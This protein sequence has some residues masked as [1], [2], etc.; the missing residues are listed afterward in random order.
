[1][2]FEYV[3]HVLLFRHYAFLCCPHDHVVRLR[4]GNQLLVV[5]GLMLSSHVVGDAVDV[6]AQIHALLILSLLLH[7][8]RCEHLIWLRSL[9]ELLNA[10]QFVLL[11]ELVTLVKVRELNQPRLLLENHNVK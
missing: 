4:E 5:N 2:E 7:V 6:Q 10:V 9:F 3:N 1:M 8:V 11:L